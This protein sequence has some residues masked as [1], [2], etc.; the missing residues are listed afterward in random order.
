M[1]E[2]RQRSIDLL[3]ATHEFPCKVMVKVIGTNSAAFMTEVVQ[4][5][6]VELRLKFD[7]PIRTR[8]TKGGRHISITLEPYFEN[9]EEVLDVY[10]RFRSIDGVV[11]VL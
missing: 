1:N 3:N 7:P 8:E 9:A 11:M 5:V 2:D 4:S 6:R 10:D